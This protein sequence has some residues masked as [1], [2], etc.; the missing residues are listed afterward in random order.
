MQQLAGSPQWLASQGVGNGDRVAILGRNSI[1]WVVTF[2]AS[3]SL[4]AVAVGLNAWWSAEELRYGIDDCE[5]KVVVDDMSVVTPLLSGEPVPLPEVPL[6]DVAIDED[7]PAVIL[8]TSGTTG[9]AKGAT[10]SH[11]NVVGLVQAQ[12]HLAASRLPLGM[13]LPPARILNSTP[14]FHVS[15]L[16]S[17]VVAGLAAGSTTVWQPGRFDPAA[18]LK[19]IEQERCTTWT[20][21]ADDGV[22]R[23]A[24]P[25]RVVATTRARCGT[26]G[27][28]RGL[29]AGACSRRSARCSASRCRGASATG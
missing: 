22:A 24:P 2:W 9:R 29:V 15:G 28:R 19:L 12:Q 5:P 26:S 6:P 7:D 16:H 1:E 4:G 23:R 10:H 14:L 18:T 17:G 11:R 13:T 8:Y 27:R 25:G 21:D 20:D 3:V